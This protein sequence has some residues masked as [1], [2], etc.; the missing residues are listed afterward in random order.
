MGFD[1]APVDPDIEAM[2]LDDAGAAR[3]DEALSGVT[4]VFARRAQYE[5]PD[6]TKAIDDVRPDALI[7]DP[8]CWGAYAGLWL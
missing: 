4:D 1:T 6:L 8:N 2:P 7:L 5:I 3:P